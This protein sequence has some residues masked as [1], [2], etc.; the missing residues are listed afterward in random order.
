MLSL[1]YMLSMQF[2]ISCS[3]AFWLFSPLMYVSHLP[4]NFGV[5]SSLSNK[6]VW[7]FM[8]WCM[9]SMV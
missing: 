3:V 5:V 7:V 2:I 1:F 6:F 4:M 8:K 9:A